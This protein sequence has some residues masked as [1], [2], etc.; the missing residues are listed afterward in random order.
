MD[1][2]IFLMGQWSLLNKRH[3]GGVM[4]MPIIYTDPG[5]TANGTYDAQFN[6]I[7]I[8]ERLFAGSEGTCLLS[9]PKYT[10]G[11]ELFITDTLLHEMC[12]QYSYLIKKLPLTEDPHGEVFCS[13][14]NRIG[15]DLGFN[16]VFLEKEDRLLSCN[17]WPHNVRGDYFGAFDFKE[18]TKKTLYCSL[19]FPMIE[20][21]ICLGCGNHGP[22]K[23]KEG[24]LLYLFCEQCDNSLTA[25]Q[26]KEII[27]DNI[28]QKV[29]EML[30]EIRKE[31]IK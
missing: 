11:R 2:N 14:C 28:A 1:N 20:Q 5:L 31:M 17:Q 10:A 16:P 6:Q 7:A 19:L 8:N 23:D 12:H 29:S 22:F 13:E 9:G 15:G 27:D 4:E 25:E 3:F 30:V 24:K 26:E 21:N 18:N